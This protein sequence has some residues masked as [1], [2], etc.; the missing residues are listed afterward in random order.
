MKKLLLMFALGAMA[1]LT[2]APAALAQQASSEEDVFDCADFATQTGAQALLAPEDPAKLDRDGDGKACETGPEGKAEDGTK[3]AAKTG[4]DL[5]CIDFPS[6]K[7]AQAKLKAKPSDADGLDMDNDGVACQI[8]PVPYEDGAS[9]RAPVA[10]AKS[11]AKLD[12]SDFEYQQEAQMIL[13]RDGSDPNGL[14][15]DKDGLA[16]EKELPGFAAN[17]ETIEVEQVSA[18]SSG[19]LDPWLLL[20]V[21]GGIAGPGALGFAAWRRHR[22]SEG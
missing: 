7:A 14:D 17:E 11:T 13:L 8:V 19:G 10:A 5:D 16:C 2:L 18:P 20:V 1:V 12:C 6:Q 22:S 4:G 3:L 9:D 15:D 21:A